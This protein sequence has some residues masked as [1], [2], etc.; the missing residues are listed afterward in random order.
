MKLLLV[1]LILF[2]TVVSKAQK[3]EWNRKEEK[4]NYY[5]NININYKTADQKDS[6]RKIANVTGSTSLLFICVSVFSFTFVSDN[7]NVDPDILYLGIAL[8]SGAVAC[9]VGSVALIYNRKAKNIQYSNSYRFNK[10]IDSRQSYKWNINTTENG[11]GLVC[12][13]Y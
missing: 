3:T 2:S 13:F 12:N 5:A 10:N 4:I 7:N 1:I 9:I 6:Y 8:I 11:I